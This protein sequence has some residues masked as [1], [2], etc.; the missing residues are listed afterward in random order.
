MK[1]LQSL[2]IY[3]LVTP[4]IA[5]GASNLLA[6]EVTDPNVDS[7]PMSDP[8]NNQDDEFSGSSNTDT[9]QS[10]QGTL[11]QSGM[12]NRGYLESAPANSMNA[13]DLIGSN[14][15]TDGEEEVGSISELIIDENGQVVAVVVGV[16]GFLGMGEKDV[17]IGWDDVTKTGTGDNQE[18]RIRMTRDE[19]SSAP[20][21]ERSE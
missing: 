15:T 2:A 21:F 4:V 7:D 17:A 20:G 11:G 13:S 6:E 1:K 9:T 18:L 5:F 12:E 16:G 14:I 8:M 3:A 19:L 10:D